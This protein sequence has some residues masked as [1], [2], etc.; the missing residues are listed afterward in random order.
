[1]YKKC[2]DVLCS[3]DCKC[4]IEDSDI[5][6][7]KALKELNYDEKK[8][9]INIMGC[10]QYGKIQKEM[11]WEEYNYNHTNLITTLEITFDCSGIC[12]PSPLYL[13]SDVNRGPPT[14]KLSCFEALD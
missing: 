5:Y 3:D 8:G 9:A 10:K 6:D 1:M 7:K 13:F 12:K 2:S 11:G 4:K 14:N